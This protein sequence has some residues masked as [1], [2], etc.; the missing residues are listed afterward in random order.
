MISTLDV[1]PTEG[2]IDQLRF[3]GKAQKFVAPREANR[4]IK[5]FW[6]C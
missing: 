4:I 2:L 3:T 5:K 1:I 6:S